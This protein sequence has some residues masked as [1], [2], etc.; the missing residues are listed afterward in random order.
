MALQPL[1]SFDSAGTLPDLRLS[2][3]L[4]SGTRRDLSSHWFCSRS[5]SRDAFTCWSALCCA[6]FAVFSAS[7]TASADS[8]TYGA[9]PSFNTPCAGKPAPRRQTHF[10][11]A[12]WESGSAIKCEASGRAGE[13]TESV[14]IGFA[15]GVLSQNLLPLPS[16][17]KCGSWLE[18]F[19]GM[20]S[21]ARMQ[22]PS[23]EI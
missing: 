8:M 9:A 13:L 21:A 12:H 16:G 18:M 5:V 14:A 2:R 20:T 17:G 10:Q 23:T 4:S 15:P 3:A 22:K 1:T 7:L 19:R 11:K 6:A